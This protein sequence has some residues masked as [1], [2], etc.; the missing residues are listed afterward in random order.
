MSYDKEIKYLKSN[1]FK[2]HT[3]GN[4]GLYGLN[5]L[6]SPSIIQYKNELYIFIHWLTG[7]NIANYINSEGETF[8]FNPY[9]KNLETEIRRMEEDTDINISDN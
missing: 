2:T 4:S 1:K 5:F 7:T 9:N 8:S 6:G 3:R